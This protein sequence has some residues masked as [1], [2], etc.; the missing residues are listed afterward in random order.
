M[1]NWSQVALGECATIVSG[2][3]PKTSM[4]EYWNGN[5]S[6]ATPTDIANLS[7]G[8]CRA[9]ARQISELGLQSC[10]AT[11]LPPG[12]VLFSSRAPIGHVAI[13][14]VP[15]ATNQ[16]FKSLIPGDRL[17]NRYL[18]WWLKAHRPFLESLGNGATFKEVSKAVVERIEIPLPPL[19]EQR[20]I[21]AILDQTDALRQLCERALLLLAALEESKFWDLF[22]EEQDDPLVKV[23]SVAASIRTG[24]FGSQLLHSEFTDQGVAV[25]GIDNAVSNEFVWAKSRFISEAKYQVLKRYR[26][27]PGDV[28]LTIM[29]TCGRVA[30]VPEGIPISINT[31]HLCCI[32]PDTSKVLPEYLHGALLRHPN[33]LRQLGVS[34]RGAVMPGLNMQLIKDAEI[35]LPSMERQNQYTQFV[36]QVRSQ[37]ILDRNRLLKAN[38]LFASL[39]HRAFSGELTSA[40]SA[41]EMRKIANTV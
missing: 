14:T 3:T 27:Y 1:S 16:G 8:F 15:L 6:W 11:I 34:E 30:I 19:D 40:A 9:T 17:C 26:V 36:A 29:G 12:S 23:S 25:L 21:A 22:V 38:Q 31:K 13:N 2:A 39:Q 20:R 33:V 37:T 32:T 41:T 35:P 28:L 5:V 24:P 7:D 4:P 18:Y 10:A